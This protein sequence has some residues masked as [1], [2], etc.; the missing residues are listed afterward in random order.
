MT[1]CEYCKKKKVSL[2]PFNCKCDL[3]ILCVNCK[4]PEQH[5][6]SFDFK[7]DWKKKLTKTMPIIINSKI[8]K[9]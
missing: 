8:D 9:L 7:K 1:L 2:I 6:C 4:F 5:N 3:K